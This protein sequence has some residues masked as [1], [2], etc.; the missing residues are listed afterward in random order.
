MFRFVPAVFPVAL[1]FALAL[2]PAS[3]LP[4]SEVPPG[5]S[6]SGLASGRVQLS[7]SA[8]AGC[9]GRS[10]VDAAVVRFGGDPAA[11]GTAVEVTASVTASQGG[12]E[13]ELELRSASGQVSGRHRATRCESLVDAVGLKVALALDSVAV[14]ERI[15]EQLAAPVPPPIESPTVEPESKSRP[16]PEITT[17]RATKTERP[18]PRGFV[19]PTG[20]VG[21]GVLPGVGGGV[22]VAGGVLLPHLRAEAGATYWVPRTAED[23]MQ[24]GA[25]VRMQLVTGD[26]RPC[27]VPVL[28]PVE[29]PI[30][31]HAHLGAIYAEGLGV[32]TSTPRWRFYASAGVG[33]GASWA[34]HPNVALWVQATLDVPIVRHRFGIVGIGEIYA[35]GATAGRGALGLEFRFPRSGP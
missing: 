17:A 14:V 28:G 32:Q 18:R 15:D 3:G 20:M 7:W 29:L 13:L 33:A 22:S 31:G 11:P 27:V 4:A 12:Y 24:S 16:A 35:V 26:L 1:A 10:A 2:A 21:A 23:P 5:P 34:M 8:P 9:P 30:C 19:R 25:S 6:P